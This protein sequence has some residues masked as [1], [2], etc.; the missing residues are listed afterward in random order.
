MTS[1]TGESA[2]AEPR[3]MVEFVLVLLI[4]T[5]VFKA[6]VVDGYFVPTGSMAPGLVGLHNDL[7]CPECG[8]H[9]AVGRDSD[10]WTP[11]TVTCPSVDELKSL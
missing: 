5:L 7:T 8:Y 11:P 3:H 2:Q 1:A 6:F 10:A 4:A 9:F